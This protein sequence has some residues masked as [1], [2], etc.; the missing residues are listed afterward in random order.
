MNDFQENIV[1]AMNQNDD[2][3]F[4]YNN[5]KAKIKVLFVG[6]SI[7]KH[8]PKPSIG[9][10]RDCGMAASSIDKDYVHLIVKKIMDKY[11]ANV[12]FGIAQ[13][14]QYARTFFEK[15]PDFDYS[16]AREFGADLI[17]MF[18][19]ANVSKDYDT[20]EN[21]PKTFEVAYEDMRNYLKVKEDAIVYHSEGFYI[22]PKLEEE[23]RAVAEMY[24]DTYMDIS[25]IKALPESRGM[26][27]HPSDL[28]MQMIADKF[29]EYIEA[30]VAAICEKNG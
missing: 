28:G 6:N 27:N 13:V 2:N 14:A 20:M 21:P 11:D 19:G 22:R 10:T 12:S 5:D 9:W 16:L 29:W 30:D 26:F 18:Y 1:P 23:K 15:T 8:G 7:A 4:L 24:G 17:I 3:V 25:E